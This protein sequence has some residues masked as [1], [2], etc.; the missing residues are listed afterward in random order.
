MVFPPSSIIQIIIRYEAFTRDRL[1]WKLWWSHWISSPVCNSHVAQEYAYF[2]D[3]MVGVMSIL[4]LCTLLTTG[5]LIE[6]L[7]TLLG[8]KERASRYSSSKLIYFPLSLKLLL[9]LR[10]QTRRRYYELRTASGARQEQRHWRSGQPQQRLLNESFWMNPRES[11]QLSSSI[12][13][14]TSN[15][16]S[17]LCWTAMSYWNFP[18]LRLY[19]KIIHSNSLNHVKKINKD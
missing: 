9:T 11:E 2:L 5:A 16:W 8:S 12:Y 3:L 7:S 19:R 14:R 15:R 10:D 6:L 17:D 18:R 1:G 13:R 4:W